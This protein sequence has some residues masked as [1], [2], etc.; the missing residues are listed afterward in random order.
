ME[1]IDAIKSPS[2]K[3]KEAWRIVQEHRS[4]EPEFVESVQES[5]MSHFQ[6]DQLMRYAAE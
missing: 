2:L 1:I 5:T 6:I 3:K 4:Y